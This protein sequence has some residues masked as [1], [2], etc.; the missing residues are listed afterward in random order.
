ML[1]L[2]SYC[3]LLTFEPHM[4]QVSATRLQ[5]GCTRNFLPLSKSLSATTIHSNP[6]HCCLS[7]VLPTRRRACSPMWLSLRPLWQ[8][9]KCLTGTVQQKRSIATLS[10]LF[11]SNNNQPV[12]LTETVQLLRKQEETTRT[13]TIRRRLRHHSS[14][15]TTINP[16][17]W[18]WLYSCCQESK[19]KN[20]PYQPKQG[21]LV[22][23]FCGNCCR[24]RC[25][26]MKM[27]A[28][29]QFDWWHCLMWEDL[30]L[31]NKKTNHTNLQYDDWDLHDSNLIL[32]L[33]NVE[34]HCN[35]SY[36]S[37]VG[38]QFYDVHVRTWALHKSELYRR[39]RLVHSML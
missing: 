21:V 22:V 7:L 5:Q 25:H 27:T 20:D 1:R 9:T 30:E 12:S 32:Y 4:L 33:K 23:Q 15:A 3:I 19:R 14:T 35:F 8:M 37:T 29:C 38:L 16:S 2:Q 18:Q 11:D 10:P 17:S 39:R 36:Y 6:M 24:C 28:C 34:M 31:L 26:L 13:R